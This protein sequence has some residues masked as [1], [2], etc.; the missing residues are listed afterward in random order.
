MRLNPKLP[1]AA[2]LLPLAISANSYAEDA[3]AANEIEEIIV[4]GQKTSRSLQDT[5]ASVAVVTDVAMEEQGI[6]DF[7]EV[8]ERTANI[9]AQPGVGFNIRG[10]DA[11]NVS[12][13]GNSYLTSVYIDGAVMPYRVIQQG[14]F[15]TWDLQQVEVLRGPQSTLQGRNA[16]AGA[17]VM[18]SKN[19]S[20]EWDAKFRIG[21]GQDGRREAAFATGGSI[22]EDELAFR[23][24]GEQRQWD[25][26]NYNPTRKDTPDFFDSKNLRAKLLWEPSA[27]PEFSALLS[28]SYTDADEGTRYTDNPGE[29]KSPFDHRINAHND[30]ITEFTETDIITLELSYELGEN[31][32]F[33]SISTYTD[34]DYGYLWDGDAGP[35][36]GSILDDKRIDETLSQEFRFSFDYENFKGL[37]GA[38]YS[39]LDVDDRVTGNQQITLQ[40]LGVPTLLVAPPEFGGLGLPQDLANMVLG[41]YA[42]ADPVLLG[43]NADL[44]QAVTTKAIFADFSYNINDQWELFAGIRWD[45]ESQENSSDT[46]ITIDNVDALPK[47]EN[48][49]T[50]PT[51]AALITGLNAQLFQMAADASGVQPLVDADFSEVLP[52]LG[53]SYHWNDDITTSFTFQKGYRSGGVGSNIAKGYN[54]QFDPEFTDNYEFSFRSQWLDKRL[55]VNANAFYLDWSDQQVAVQLSGNRYDTETRNAGSSEVK[56]IEL[57]T[58]YELSDEISLY[59]SI[60]RAKTEFKEFKLILPTNTYDLSG[61]EFAG[62]PEWTGNLGITY[63]GDNGFRFNANANYTDESLSSNTPWTQAQPGTPQYDP[64]NDSRW[65]VNMRAG[66][67]WDKFGAYVQVNNLLDEEYIIRNDTGSGEL[68][69][70]APRQLSFTLEANF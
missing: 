14:A 66:Y 27:L 51:L 24:A 29:G 23:I 25:G 32:D 54:Y 42:P 35:T 33:K 1:F 63:N 5:A 57:E 61:R 47:P 34:A 46:R 21:G 18:N 68:F 40:S 45:K 30:P 65:V 60:G 19:P 43:R 53:V 13:S 49:A 2:L 36:P 4:T 7:F 3:P 12:G 11:F 17:I 22:V 10:I 26:Y 15:S 59:G 16:L 58:N 39:D 38:Y 62:A 50:N 41:L 37:I 56:G 55:T 20:H 67:E 70:G 69:L 52:K 64:N 48:F 31:W 28:Y 6:R 9:T 44:T 8:M